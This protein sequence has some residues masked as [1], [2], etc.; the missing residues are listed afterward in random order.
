MENKPQIDYTKRKK[1]IA[2]KIVLVIVL[3]TLVCIGTVGWFLFQKNV[4]DTSDNQ[5]TIGDN[6]ISPDEDGS[7]I[8][9]TVYI[10]G[11]GY[12]EVYDVPFKRTEMYISNKDLWKDHPEIMA[13][14]S[15]TAQTYVD[16]ILSMDY[17]DILDGKTGYVQH[18]TGLLDEEM[19]YEDPVEEGGKT[20]EQYAE[21]IAEYMIDNHISI[22]GKFLTDTSLIYEDGYL[23]V[24][25]VVEYI[26]YSSDDPNLPAD[27]EKKHA[28]VEL[29]IKRMSDDLENYDVV[30]FY[31]LDPSDFPQQEN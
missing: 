24:R 30:Y 4:N 12:P 1:K 28:M 20:A 29:A 11:I 10:G 16:Y 26:V 7:Y 2:D 5:S 15:D 6:T 23:F 25:G 14:V 13:K 3:V 18:L 17:K 19:F 27:G 31:E 8:G 21:S 9:E 22:E